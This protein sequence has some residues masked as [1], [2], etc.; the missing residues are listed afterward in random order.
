L[1][2][3]KLDKKKEPITY[4]PFVFFLWIAAPTEAC[5]TNSF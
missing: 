2:R 5:K 4:F 3:N 1:A